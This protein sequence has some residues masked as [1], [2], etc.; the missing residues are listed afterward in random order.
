HRLKGYMQEKG[1]NLMLFLSMAMD[2]IDVLASQLTP[3]LQEHRCEC[4]QCEYYR[5]PE[6]QMVAPEGLTR[7][8]LSPRRFHQRGCETFCLIEHYYPYP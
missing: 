5:S 7:E 3:Q 6:W 1:Y 2:V 4:S 8:A